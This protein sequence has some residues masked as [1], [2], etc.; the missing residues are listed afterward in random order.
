M[1]ILSAALAVIFFA[2]VV[3]VEM[4]IILI[5]IVTVQVFNRQFW[6]DWVAG[7]F[8]AAWEFLEECGNDDSYEDSCD[9]MG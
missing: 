4:V 8:K 3:V 7:F 6:R 1:G 9:L 5:G 2:I